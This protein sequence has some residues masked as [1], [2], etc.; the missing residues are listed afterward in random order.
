MLETKY[1]LLNIAAVILFAGAASATINKSI[2]YVLTP[3]YSP[4]TQKQ[5]NLT[6]NTERKLSQDEL[7]STITESG[8][9][10]V[11]GVVNDSS[12][13]AGT[14][15]S[16]SVSNLTLLG[17][18]TGPAII[19]RAVIQRSGDKDP[20]VFALYKISAQIDNNVYGYKLTNINTDRVTLQ[21]N[22]EK[23]VLELFAK[24]KPVAGANPNANQGGSN[25]VSTTMSRAEIKQSVMNNLDEAMKGLV[26]GP[27]RK[28]GQLEG[29]LLRRVNQDN[30]LYKFGI[31]SGDIVKRVNG[32]ALNSVETLMPMW[33]NLQNESKITAD[34]ERGGRMMTFDLNITE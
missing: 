33:Q 34:V 16:E 11:S 10:K 3:D 8:I 18:V 12:P 6:K 30:I 14:G 4:T 5:T 1:H 25:R 15:S 7:I 21:A 29:Y 23:I 9:F 24:N 19:A 20:K 27:Y 22:G 31:R 2:Q 17:T 26:A 32:K 13:A 28:N